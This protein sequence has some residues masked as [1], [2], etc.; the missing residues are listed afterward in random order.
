MKL[1]NIINIILVCATIVLVAVVWIQ[2]RDLD[3]CRLMLSPSGECR[4]EIIARV[5]KVECDCA[6]TMN[7]RPIN[8]TNVEPPGKDPAMVLEELKDKAAK[9]AAVT[10]DETGPR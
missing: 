9:D 4:A 2:A 7:G 1:L 10:I 5:E 3:E 6:W 8:V